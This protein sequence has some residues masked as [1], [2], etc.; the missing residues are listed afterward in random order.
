MTS[1]PIEVSFPVGLPPNTFEHDWTL[2]GEVPFLC[3]MA[4]KLPGNIAEIGCYRGQTTLALARMNPTKTVYAIDR[5]TREGL[6]ERQLQ[7]GPETICELA[8]GEPNVQVIVADSNTL[9]WDQLK[10][11]SL[12][13]ID[14]NHSYEGVRADSAKAF[15]YFG[16]KSGVIVWHDYYSGGP[17]ESWLEVN[18][19]LDGLIEDGFAIYRPAN[20]IL[21][22]MWVGPGRPFDEWFRP[23]PTFS[24]CHTTARLPDGWRNA[25]QA[26]FDKCD[27]PENVEYVLVCDAP[28]MGM[29]FRDAPFPNTKTGLNHGRKCAVDGWNATAK[30]ATGRV[31]ITVAD[32]WTPCD[33]WDTELLKGIPDLNGEYVVNVSTGGDTTLLTF[34]ILTRAFFD[35]LTKDYGYE[36]G[37]FYKEYLGMYGDNDFTEIASRE[38]VVL[39]ATH[40]SFPHDHPLYT[41]KPMDAVHQHQHRSEAWEVGQR[42]FQRRLRENFGK[43]KTLQA[44]D[45]K[46]GLIA[47]L[48]PG[49]NFSAAWVGQWTML[50]STLMETYHVHVQMGQSSN[51]YMTRQGL[52]D[53]LKCCRPKPDLILWI[54]D[55]QI[56][57]VDALRYMLRDLEEHPELAGVVGWAWCEADTYGQ[58]PKLSCGAWDEN[59]KPTRMKYEDLMAG[60]EDLKPISYSGFPAVLLR[61][62]VFDITG[63]RSFMPIFD[64]DLFPPFGMSGE[65]VAFFFHARD[66]GLK[67]AVDRRVKVPHLKLRCAEPTEV[68]SLEGAPV[69]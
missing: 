19:Y 35:R 36:G 21:A 5:L 43:P 22:F 8:K 66:K 38:N 55:D 12:I 47:C 37:F 9:D 53:A 14:G 67:F 64:E 23:V 40:L 59:E 68:T 54:D 13:F 26:W 30:L 27:H 62:S 3:W 31:L 45:Q 49:E 24:L 28:G 50:L 56:L 52:A 6:P 11:V 41:G 34:S 58:I 2:N 51:V 39:N 25:A 63:P 60:P 61:G 1:K 65:D 48:L 32:D 20:S 46:K 15:Q 29:V 33:H 4:A 42:V 16:N 10:D 69:K 17:P 18:R 7:P 57:T 44:A